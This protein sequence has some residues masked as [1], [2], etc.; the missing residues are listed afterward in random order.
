M[1][2][3]AAHKLEVTNEDVFTVFA[4]QLRQMLFW[5]HHPSMKS[6][7]SETQVLTFFFEPTDLKKFKFLLSFFFFL[8]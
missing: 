6:I 3:A 4:R 8:N 2:A 1:D 7:P 5:Q